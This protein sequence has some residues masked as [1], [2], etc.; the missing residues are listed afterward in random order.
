MAL[1]IPWKKDSTKVLT[2]ICLG[3]SDRW[4]HSFANHSTKWPHNIGEGDGPT[5]LSWLQTRSPLSK[6]IQR[7]SF[8]NGTAYKDFLKPK[9]NVEAWVGI[10]HLELTINSQ[11][12]LVTMK[13]ILWTTRRTWS[14][15]PRSKPHPYIWN[16]KNRKQTSLN[17]IE[18]IGKKGRQKN[19]KG[20]VIARSQ[21]FSL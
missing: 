14:C 5:S 8:K 18:N 15:T 3:R 20:R 4:D 1:L 13:S 9:N 6:Q 11:I 21:R 12:R 16:C 17:K 2:R 19:E 10:K 7:H